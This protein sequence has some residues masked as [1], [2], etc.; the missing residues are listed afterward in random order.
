LRTSCLRKPR[1]KLA[2]SAQELPRFPALRAKRF[3]AQAMHEPVAVALLAA[4]PAPRQAERGTQMRHG[5]AR[6]RLVARP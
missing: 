5:A 2:R 1:E 6:R 3:C 4:T